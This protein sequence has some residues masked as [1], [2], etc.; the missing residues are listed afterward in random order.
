MILHYLSYVT[1][2][3]PRGAYSTY[4]KAAYSTYDIAH[5]YH[6]SIGNYHEGHICRPIYEH[7]RHIAPLI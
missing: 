1:Q 7:Q 5:I 6:M 4:D 2:Q 3:L